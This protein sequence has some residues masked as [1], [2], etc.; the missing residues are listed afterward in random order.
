MK[1]QE[2]KIVSKLIKDLF[3][4][5]LA[6][7]YVDINFELKQVEENL[8]FIFKIKNLNSELIELI[9]LKANRE[10]ELEV[11]TYGFELMGDIDSKSELEIAGL[12]ID[13]VIVNQ[14]NYFIVLSFVR[15]DRYL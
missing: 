6:H 10:R 8:L 13:E 3:S 15:K 1:K 7:G 9:K 2:I 11:E 4:F 14:E 5:F 12:L